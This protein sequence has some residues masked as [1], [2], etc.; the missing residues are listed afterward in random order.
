[1]TDTGSAGGALTLNGAGIYT[2]ALTISDGT[3]L[4]ASIGSDLHLAIG[5]VLTANLGFTMTGTA[6]PVTATLAT[7]LTPADLVIG[8]AAVNAVAIAGIVTTHT[9]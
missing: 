1:V 4:G 2:G 6:T 8:S 3:N 5:V 7:G 9:A